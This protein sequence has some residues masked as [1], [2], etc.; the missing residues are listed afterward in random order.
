MLKVI[1]LNKKEYHGERFNNLFK[2]DNELSVAEGL[3]A[4]EYI[5]RRKA[6]RKH[7]MDLHNKN[8]NCEFP[9]SHKD[10]KRME[11]P[12]KCEIPVNIVDI[13]E[14]IIAEIVQY[15]KEFN[16]RS[17]DNY[18]VSCHILKNTIDTI[19][20]FKAWL[21]SHDYGIRPECDKYRKETEYVYNRL[22]AFDKK[23]PQVF[24]DLFL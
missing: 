1:R 24:N 16:Y 22:I 7:I 6:L 14:I 21:D 20:I 3:V 9:V 8:N 18:I 13:L 2:I 11:R 10:I 12:Y 5:P 17:Q 19:T 23:Y 15:K 4:F